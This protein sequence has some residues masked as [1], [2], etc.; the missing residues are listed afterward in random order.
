M[1]EAGGGRAG[2]GRGERGGRGRGRGRDGRGRKSGRD[3][4]KEEWIP[5]TKL[6]RLVKEGT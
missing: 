1:A 5:V 3:T 6:G 2:F 4:D